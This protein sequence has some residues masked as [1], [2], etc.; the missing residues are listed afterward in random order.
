VE[1]DRKGLGPTGKLRVAVNDE[2]VSDDQ[3]KQQW[4][5]LAEY[6]KVDPATDEPTHRACL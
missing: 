4:P 5:A 2:A 1:N 3:P 6:S